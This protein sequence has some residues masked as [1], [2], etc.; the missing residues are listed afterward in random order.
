M[1]PKEELDRAKYDFLSNLIEI[2]IDESIKIAKNQVTQSILADNKI[3]INWWLEDEEAYNKIRILLEG[4]DIELNPPNSTYSI[5]IIF[6]SYMG[7]FP[8]FYKAALRHLNP[9]P[10]NENSDAYLLPLQEFIYKFQQIP[11]DEDYQNNYPLFEISKKIVDDYNNGRLI[12]EITPNIFPKYNWNGEKIKLAWRKGTKKLKRMLEKKQRLTDSSQLFNKEDIIFQQINVLVLDSD[13]LNLDLM[14]DQ[15]ER[16]KELNKSPNKS[17][18][19]CDSCDDYFYSTGIPS[20]PDYFPQEKS[21]KITSGFVEPHLY[22]FHADDLKRNEIFM[23]LI[24]RKTCNHEH[25]HPFIMRGTPSSPTGLINKLLNFQS[26]LSFF[27]CFFNYGLLLDGN[28]ES[29][30][31]IPPSAMNQQDYSNWDIRFTYFIDEMYRPFIPSE[32]IHTNQCISLKK[33]F[34]EQFKAH[35]ILPNWDDSIYQI[36][37]NKMNN[38]DS[39]AYSIEPN[40]NQEISYTNPKTCQLNWHVLGFGLYE[41]K[42]MNII[43]KNK[44]SAQR[45]Q[46]VSYSKLRDFNQPIKYIILGLDNH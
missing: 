20:W 32:H 26:N 12:E 43:N 39:I 40:S 27:S 30:V 41:G 18:F 5:K 15:V 16:L 6:R 1:Y 21:R 37:I 25:N 29:Q 19:F 28:L 44:A 22:A 24:E 7:E 36:V 9:T 10:P 34:S 46:V 42:G 33:E 4:H 31:K 17:L 13:G 38:I 3:Q 8:N 2:V 23:R 14:K 11:N 45:K 35:N